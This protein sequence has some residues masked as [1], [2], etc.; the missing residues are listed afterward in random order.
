MTRMLKW[1]RLPAQR[2]RA[3]HTATLVGGSRMLV[4]GGRCGDQFMNDLW[5]FDLQR[6]KWRQLQEH[7][8]FAARAY[9]SAT[10]VGKNTLW[11]I[12]GS[13][14]KTIHDD[15]HAL[16]TETLEWS[17]PVL[18]SQGTPRGTH[19]AV[20]HPLN[21]KCIL[22][23]GG[24]GGFKPGTFNWLG[25]LSVLNTDSL[26]WEVLQPGGNCPCSRGYHSFTTF[27]HNVLLFGGKNNSGIVEEDDL[28]V[29]DAFENK[30]FTIKP[31]GEA[32]CPRSNHAAVLAHETSIF[33]HGG[34]YG[35]SRLND[36]YSLE[37]A[38]SGASYQWQNYDSKVVDSK[39]RT[40]KIAD[41]A[42]GPEGRAAHCLVVCNDS[43][44]MLGGY[45]GKG[46]TFSD[47]YVVRRLPQK[48]RQTKSKATSRKVSF[49]SLP[50]EGGEDNEG[51]FSTRKEALSAS[52]TGVGIEAD[53][54]YHWTPEDTAERTVLLGETSMKPCS[55]T[56]RKSPPGSPQEDLAREVQNM[57]N[58]RLV[59][60]G[61]VAAAQAGMTKASTELETVQAEKERLQRRV[62]ALQDQVDTEST[63]A[64]LLQRE[65]EERV[66]AS[67]RTEV[68]STQ[69]REELQASALKLDSKER[70]KQD[71]H[72]QLKS[73]EKKLDERESSLERIKE[74]HED[75]VLERDEYKSCVQ[76]LDMALQKQMQA[77][78]QM[79]S[80]YDTERSFLLQARIFGFIL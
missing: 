9:H 62:D 5:E 55:S 47:M 56:K 59:L 12:G 27:G 69:L 73:V 53:D 49:V 22:V 65:L 6:E 57:R 41:A 72:Y 40:L 23:F 42:D 77:L 80:N 78:Q 26:Q 52:H 58:K 1:E 25:D 14:A 54:P 79:K 60:E 3:G 7:A 13:D 36:I 46:G 11:I 2:A 10:V 29:Y 67:Q 35:K 61:Q 75:A 32:P 16:N 43:L 50:L 38:A 34:R 30:W 70:E 31:S 33:V 28:S 20:I 21:P 68:L 64:S 76:K 8:P 17:T 48:G 71:L 39:S 45:G 74:L 4:F 51:W 19:A 63:K 66:I 24:Y 15:V 18:K 44:Y 37:I